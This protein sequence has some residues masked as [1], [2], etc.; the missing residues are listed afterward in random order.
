MSTQETV[1]TAAADAT[2]AAA[3]ATQAASQTLSQTL[4][5]KG[6]MKTAAIV[7]G[8]TAVA[9]G[10]GYLAYKGYGL[11][12]KK[13]KAMRANKSVQAG[14][15]K[16]AEGVAEATQGAAEAVAQPAQ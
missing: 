12:S 10:L 2:Q 8:G 15:S 1:I 4:F 16:V 7:A 3:Q 9:A 5:N 6:H 14:A 13:V 11:V